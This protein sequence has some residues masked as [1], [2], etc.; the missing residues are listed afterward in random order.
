MLEPGVELDI[1]VTIGP[2]PATSARAWIAAA[3][4]TMSIL[5]AQT[6]LDVPWDVLEAFERYLRDWRA[7]ADA[8]D[9]F[10][11][12]D[13]VD[14]RFVTRIGLHWA[15]ITSVARAGRVP[16]IATAPAEA[17]AFYDAVA[18]GI[19]SALESGSTSAEIA[20]AFCD[21]VPAFET[22]VR[23][24]APTSA[25]RVLVV[26]DH[27]DLRLLVRVWF[28]GDGDFELVGETQTGHAAIQVA[29]STQ[30]HVVI[31]DIDGRET[32]A[33]DSVAL[34]RGAAPGAVVIVYS[35]QARRLE[36]LSAGATAFLPKSLPISTV[37]DVA[38]RSVREVSVS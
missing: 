16:S 9:V 1:T 34:V 26:G 20:G 12:S 27:E 18:T 31:I 15:R 28:E 38:R 25:I 17:A 36:A 3:E 5:R 19:A 14:E 35:G 4:E 22:A 10:V 37:L 6:E 7:V 8:S 30:P 2:V 13:R 21:A 23:V 33:A 24:D 11:W 29:R 32:S